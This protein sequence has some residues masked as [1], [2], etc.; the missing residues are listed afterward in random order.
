MVRA[1][2]RTIVNNL[3]TDRGTRHHAR[4]VTT[5]VVSR[6]WVLEE[7]TQ[8]SNHASSQVGWVVQMKLAGAEIYALLLQ[9]LNI[10]KFYPRLPI[11]DI[12][13]KFTGL[14]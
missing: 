6:V 14:F 5:P 13:Q 12:A 10:P 1:I 11:R 9:A 3:N 7:I 8:H 4:Q 2:A